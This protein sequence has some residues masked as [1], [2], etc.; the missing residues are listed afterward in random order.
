MYKFSIILLFPIIIIVLSH[1]SGKANFAPCLHSLVKKIKIMFHVFQVMSLGFPRN[2][3]KFQNQ[4]KEEA[5]NFP[6]LRLYEE[7]EP[8]WVE[9]T[10]ASI[11]YT[12]IRTSLRLV[13]RSSKSQVQYMGW[14]SEFSKVS[15]PMWGKAWNFSKSQSL[16]GVKL[17]IFSSPGLI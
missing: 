11:L 3:S 1:S 13:L 14:W 15:Q 2:S 6:C 9:K 7:L 12:T 10:W 8:I 17:R 16:Y 5:Q 4:C